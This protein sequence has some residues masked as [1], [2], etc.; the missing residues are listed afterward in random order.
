MGTLIHGMPDLPNK[1]KSSN[2]E[3][4]EDIIKYIFSGIS[5]NELVH[6]F[7]IYS[8]HTLPRRTMQHWCSHHILDNNYLNLHVKPWLYSCVYRDQIL[9]HSD[10]QVDDADTRLAS[11]LKAQSVRVPIQNLVAAGW[12]PISV[13][14]TNF[15]IATAIQDSKVPLSRFM[16]GKL[17]FL[18]THY[19]EQ[20][21][22]LLHEML[23]RGIRAVKNV[24]PKYHSRQYCK[25]LLLRSAK[26]A[27]FNLLGKV[28]ALKNQQLISIGGKNPGYQRTVLSYDCLLSD[29]STLLSSVDQDAEVDANHRQLVAI[30]VARLRTRG[31]VHE[32][33]IDALSGY[34]MEFSIWLSDRRVHSDNE[35][36]LESVGI[37]EYMKY[38]ATW[39]EVSY[40]TIARTMKEIKAALS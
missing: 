9:D 15:I 23:Y 25:N 24:W 26:N 5:Y 37:H 20:P 18:T 38:M 34:H 22:D 19:G 33:V 13:K 32:A 12:K 40:S 10:F 30:S 17:R 2:R 29:N 8:D 35:I 11:L 6:R 39:L 1:G 36:L 16:Y 31:P 27:G 3:I 4:A 21:D 7:M 14:R 28:T